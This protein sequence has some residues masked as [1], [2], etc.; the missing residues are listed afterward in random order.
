MLF[1][2]RGMKSLHA[3]DKYKN[4]FETSIWTYVGTNPRKC[5][6]PNAKPFVMQKM[7]NHYVSYARAQDGMG[8]DF[9]LILLLKRC[10][11]RSIQL[12]Q[13]AKNLQSLTS[14]HS[15]SKFLEIILLC[16]LL[17]PY[18]HAKFRLFQEI[19]VNPYGHVNANIYRGPILFNIL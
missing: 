8:C 4:C 9:T 7:L 19:V 14:F 5:V 2:W 17:I 13:T 10:R 11:A 16:T 15:K 3:T 18:K 6:G 12:P 1:I